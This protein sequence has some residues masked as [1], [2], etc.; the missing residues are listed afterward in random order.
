MFKKKKKVLV[1]GTY[2]LV[3][4]SVARRLLQLGYEVYG[5]DN[6][7]RGV[8]FKLDDKPEP[9]EHKSY[10]HFDIDIR[11]LELEKKLNQKFDVIVH[12]AAQPSHDLADKN[13][14]LDFDVNVVGTHKLL[15]MARINSPKCTFIYLSTTKIYSDK[16]N[17]SVFEEDTRY[18]SLFLIDEQ[19]AT[20]GHHGMFGVHKLMSDNLV[21]EYGLHYGLTTIVLRP[22][23]ITGKSHR[24]TREHGFLAYLAQCFR[25]NKEYI[26]NGYGGKQVRDQIHVEDL[27]DAII[28]IIKK[29]HTD[30]YVIGGGLDNSVS[31]LEAIKLFEQKTG[32]TIQI[33]RAHV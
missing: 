24:G 22:G 32:K 16:I 11:S 3:G 7:F 8:F 20:T 26:I 14:N 25:E 29:P 12:C 30:D 27:T 31:I 2:G 9:I 6:N 21:Q 17:D 23:C 1:T 28:E 10:K 19:T 15:E 13:P 4:G 5:I 18:N 33:G